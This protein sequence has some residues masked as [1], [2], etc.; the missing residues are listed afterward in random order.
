MRKTKISFHAQLSQKILTVL[1]KKA[2]NSLRFMRKN[3]AKVCKKNCAKIAQILRKR[4]SHF[5]ETLSVCLF[6]CL[7]V[8]N[9]RQNGWTNRAQFF[10]GPRKTLGKDDRIFKK[11]LLTKFDFL[12]FEKSTIFFYKIREI[13]VCFSFIMFTKRTCSQYEWKM[14]AKRPNSLVY[15]YFLMYVLSS[16]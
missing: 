10:V 3:S 4:F 1:R 9:K 7:L 6:V 16:C 5:V 14:G 8:S 11:L 15:K 2:Q 12:K 13:F